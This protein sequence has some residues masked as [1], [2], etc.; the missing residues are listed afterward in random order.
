VGYPAGMPTHPQVDVPPGHFFTGQATHLL[1]LAALLPGP[2]LLAAPSLGDGAFL[3]LSDTAWLAL[4]VGV[5]VVHQLMVALLWRA[6]L[7]HRLLTRLLGE[8]DLVVWGA[9]FLPLL[10]ARPLTLIG[11]GCADLG[12]A[13]LPWVVSLSLG[14]LLLIPTVYTGHSIHR[15]FGIPRAL[16]GDHFRETYRQMPIVRE[17]AFAW[18][19]NAMYTLAFLGLWAIALLTGSRAALAACL[20]EHAY[21]W[22]HWYCTEEPDIRVL[23]PA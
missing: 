9:L 1:F 22:V 17:G 7:C 21:I 4:A 13:G 8:W 14:G 18:S 20:F 5:P 11:L 15:Y 16:G 10:F 12:S 6:Q 23:Y 19:S 3:G 2:L